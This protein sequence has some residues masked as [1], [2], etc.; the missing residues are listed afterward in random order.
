M[1]DKLFPAPP[2]DGRIPL[3]AQLATDLLTEHGLAEV[4]AVPG[5]QLESLRTAI[6]ALVRQ[7]TGH[8]IR[9]LVRDDMIHMVCEPVYDLHAEEYQRIAVRAIPSLLLD[10]A[11]AEP[12]A[13]PDT[14]IVWDAWDVG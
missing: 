5:D 14:I 7:R 4:R 11:Q 13:L 6:R 12:P 9:T 2:P 3:I 1:L 8:P 10:G